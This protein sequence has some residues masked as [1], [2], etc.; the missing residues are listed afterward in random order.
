MRDKE[1][2][3]TIFTYSYIKQK[4][5]I[6]DA[7][8]DWKTVNIGID[9]NNDNY[10]YWYNGT[11]KDGTW[12]KGTWNDGFWEKGAW[13]DG[14]WRGGTWKDGVWKDG[15]WIKGT[16]N[17]GFWE[18]GTWYKGTWEYGIWKGGFWFDGTWTDGTWITGKIYNHKTGKY[19]ESTLPPNKCPW[20]H[21]YEG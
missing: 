8:I 1:L 11:W 6:F 19:Q 2:I 12:I 4:S 7:E 9:D 5:W 10:I 3:Q 16:W 20:S 15:T 21:S 18:S 17:D 13:K 14:L